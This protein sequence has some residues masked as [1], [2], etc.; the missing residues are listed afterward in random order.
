MLMK[1][2]VVLL[3][4]PDEKEKAIMT[5]KERTVKW[6]DKVP[7]ADKLSIFFICRFCCCRLPRDCSIEIS[8]SELW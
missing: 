8:G 6:L 3:L 7:G 4:Q 1:A 5:R 2:I